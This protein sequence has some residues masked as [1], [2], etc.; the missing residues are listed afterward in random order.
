MIE[1]PS[2]HAAGAIALTAAM[3]YGFASRRARA[4]IISLLT[5]GPIALGLYVFPLPAHGPAGGMRRA[6]AGF[7]H[8]ALVTICALMIM[9]RGLVTTGALEPATRALT[10]VWRFNHQLGLLVTLLLAMT[11]SM[12]VNDTPVLVLLL[13]IL[14]GLAAS[15]G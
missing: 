12:M 14:T 4:E 3:S 1:L 6:F 10:K 7:G 13:P 9:G 5:V 11:M 15:G 2:P 8:Y